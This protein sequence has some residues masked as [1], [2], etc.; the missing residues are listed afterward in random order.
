MAY[1]LKSQFK[2]DS[3]PAL[4]YKQELLLLLGKEWP[5]EAALLAWQRRVTHVRVRIRDPIEYQDAKLYICFST[6]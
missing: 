4:S 2:K 6:D 5:G 3:V 1:M